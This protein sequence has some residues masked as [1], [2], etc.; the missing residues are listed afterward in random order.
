MS[1]CLLGILSRTVGYWLVGLPAMLLLAFAVHLQ[2][3]GI[4]IGLSTGFAATAVL[5]RRRFGLG[6]SQATWP[7]AISSGQGKAY[8]ARR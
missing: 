2:G 1:S 4:W 6:V 7:V 3:A 5:L 8:S